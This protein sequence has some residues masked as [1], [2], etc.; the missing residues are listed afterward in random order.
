VKPRMY[1]ELPVV[2]VDDEEA[3]LSSQAK[4][5]QGAGINNLVTCQD[6]RRLMDLLAAHGA[7]AVLLDVAMPHISGEVLLQQIRDRHPDVPVIMVTASGDIDVAVRCMKAGA[8]DYMVK[9]VEPSRLVGGLRRAIDLHRLEVRYGD[10]RQ[11]LLADRLAHP[12]AFRSI[13]TRDGRMQGIFTFIE[14]IAP[15]AET[16]LVTGET[17]TGKELAAEVI[18]SLSGRSGDLVR[19]NAAGLDDAMFADTLFGHTRGAFTGAEEQRKGLVQRAEEGTLFLDEIGDLSPASQIKL[20]RL[21]EAHEYYPLGSDVARSTGARFV[22]A[23]NRRLAGLVEAGSFRRD[24][25]YRL[26]TYEILIPPLRERRADLPL[27]LDH[28]LNEAATALA[29]PRLAVPPELLTLLQTYDFP[30]NVRE[31]RSMV[32]NA[33]SRQGQKMLS[34]RAFREAM[35][36]EGDEAPPALPAERLAFPERLPTLRQVTGELIEEAL[37]R[38]KGNQAIAAGLLGITPQALSKRLKR[39][40]SRQ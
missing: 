36:H 22:L 19:V 15:T 34:L 29:K 21:I 38:A 25:Y 5:L 14:S 37:R 24:L 20:L 12:E 39:R 8:F 30:G 6:P 18:H 28:F 31:L 10:L 32:F 26:Q 17:G 40:E 7:E 27:L 9:V 35:G 1:P 16:L 4:L 13:V 33:V 11:R 23:S 2:L 3:V